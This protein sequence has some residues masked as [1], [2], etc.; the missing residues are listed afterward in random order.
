MPPLI[1]LLFPD[2]MLPP[3]WRMVC[4]AYLAVC[5]LIIAILLGGGAWKMS[6]TRGSG[7]SARSSTA[8]SEVPSPVLS[9]DRRGRSPRL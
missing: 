6:G 5:A 2:G 9:S 1:I 8:P 7:R 3:R 4:R